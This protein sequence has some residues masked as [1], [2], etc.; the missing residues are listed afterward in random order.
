MRHERQV[1]ILNRIEAAGPR[2]V[3]LFGDDILVEPAGAYTDADRF[4][5]EQQLFRDPCYFALSAEC[6]RPGHYVSGNLGGVPITVVRQDDGTVAGLVNACRHRGAPIFEERGEIGGRVACRYHSWTYER[7]GSLAARPLSD[8]AFDQVTMACDLHRVAVAER[9]GIIYVR[10]G[11]TEPID[12]D[13]VLGGAQDDLGAFGLDGYTHLETRSSV[14]KMNWK[15]VVDTF[16]ES[17]HVR[18]LHRETIA[19]S[20]L[21][22]VALCERF[23]RN[24]TSLGLRN[25]VSQ[26]FPKTA[27]E[28]SLLPYGTMQYMLVPSGLVVHQV[29]HLE[30]WRFEPIDAR[31]TRTVTSIFSPSPPATE[32]TR[33]YFIKN[34][35][36][37]LQVVGAE[38]FPLMEQ[39]QMNLESGALPEVVF[40]R[41]E[42]ALVAFH[43]SVNNLLGG[44]SG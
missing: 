24:V 29:D 27:A 35:D 26:E 14:W 23:G 33:R 37:L 31:T 11:G 39:I 9:Y 19:P 40:G 22:D 16:C 3:G 2:C 38:D 32:K 17:Y 6:A 42:P 30:T 36:L 41:V 44:A 8:G 15:L 43:Q 28:K 34:L 20:F 5:R 7:D 10:T 21:S 1:E 4:A 25:D 18:W 13:D 12:I